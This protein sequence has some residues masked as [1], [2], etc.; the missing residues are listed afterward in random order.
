MPPTAYGF[1]DPSSA[2]ERC[3]RIALHSLDTAATPITPCR[4]CLFNVMARAMSN[5]STLWESAISHQ[6]PH[7]G[8]PFSPSEQQLRRSKGATAREA[9]AARSLQPFQG[10]GR[11]HDRDTHKNACGAG[12]WVVGTNPCASSML[13]GCQTRGSKLNTSSSTL[14]I[15]SVFP[16]GCDKK[17]RP[18]ACTPN[19]AGSPFIR[20]KTSGSYTRSWE[21]G[22]PRR[23]TNMHIKF[24]RHRTEFNA[25]F[26]QLFFLQSPHKKTPRNIKQAHLAGRGPQTSP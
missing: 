13:E 5:K 7:T 14:C 10:Q 24:S 3:C 6:R 20:R 21:I 8:A 16:A 9:L 19:T 26:L 17:S 2:S 1:R 15:A 23:K 25:R 22:M 18:S 12:L 4:V 11:Q